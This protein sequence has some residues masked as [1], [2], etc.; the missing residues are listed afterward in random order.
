[1]VDLVR[2]VTH[3]KLFSKDFQFFLRDVPFLWLSLETIETG[4]KLS[5]ERTLA[6]FDSILRYSD[7]TEFDRI[8]NSIVQYI[9]KPKQ[10]MPNT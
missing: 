4:L 5:G 8:L 9:A 3:G 6:A 2:F 10:R 7:C 1:M